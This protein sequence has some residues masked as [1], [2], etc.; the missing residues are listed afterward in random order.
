MIKLTQSNNRKAHY[1]LLVS[2]VLVL[3]TPIFSQFLPILSKYSTD[4]LILVIVFSGVSITLEEYNKPGLSRVALMTVVAASLLNM[5]VESIPTIQLIVKSLIALF[6]FL[7]TFILIKRMLS[8][9]K[10]NNI[11]IIH[12]MSGYLL[13]GFSGS[14][15]V[16]L[17]T[18]FVPHP[19]SVSIPD[20]LGSYGEVYYSF[21][22][23][24]TLGYGDINPTHGFTQALAVIIAISG[25]FYMGFLVG[26][27]IGAF[28]S[29]SNK[30]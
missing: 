10:V 27:L 9:S 11:M 2:L 1:V 23:L 14:I 25:V 28:I 26:A 15:L 4:A 5:F 18:R 30:S 24:T 19:Y 3:I 13:L 22:T 20:Q 21:V 12:A 8:V 29:Q 17:A 6:M 16:S 7:L